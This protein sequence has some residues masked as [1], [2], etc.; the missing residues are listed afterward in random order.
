MRERTEAVRGKPMRSRCVGRR[1]WCTC[2]AI[3]IG[4]VATAGCGSGEQAEVFEPDGGLLDLKA[5]LESAKA[6]GQATTQEAAAP[7][8][9]AVHLGADYYIRS[10][11][12]QYLW[13]T[14]LAEGPEAAGTVIAFQTAAATDGGWVLFQDGS[15]KRISAAEFA[16]AP[17]AEP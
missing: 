5:F 3:A 1:V 6:S 9:S 17:K 4:V 12:I 10:G 7:I 11:Q 2:A 16:A 14:K 8:I 13:G 15:L